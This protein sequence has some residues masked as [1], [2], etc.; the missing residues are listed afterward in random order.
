MK[1][2]KHISIKESADELTELYKESKDFLKP[3]IQLLMLLAQNPVTTKPKLARKLDV[4]YNSITKWLELYREGG[5][6]KLLEIKRG[7]YKSPDRRTLGFSPEIYAAI[8]KQHKTE[9]FQTYV[10]LHTWIKDKYFPSIK[11][12]TLIKYLNLH[13]GEELKIGRI[14]ELLI[15]ESITELEAL[16]VKCLPRIKP[17]VKMLITLKQNEQMS[18]A[19]LAKRLNVSYGSILK[20]TNIYRQGGIDEMLKYNLELVITPEVL[21]YIEKQ[22]Q[23]DKFNNFS[24]L[25][26]EVSKKYL[27][28]IKYYTLHRYI[29][30]HF[31][32]ELDAAKVLRMP[33]KE[34]IEQLEDLYQRSSASKKQRIKMLL[35][36][37]TMPGLTKIE[38]AKL[39]GV[40][41]GSIHRWYKLYK[42]GG[43]NRLME[44]RLRGRK[45]LELPSNIHNSIDRKLKSNPDMNLTELHTWVKTFHKSNLSYNKLYRYVRRHFIELP[46]VNF[47]TRLIEDRAF[48]RVA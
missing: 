31:A 9:P 48:N 11:Y 36:L 8:E 46:D 1:P 41:V 47:N 5:L 25:Y 7:K 17:R 32:S 13:F 19:E 26:K 10:E 2:I 37:K 44:I 12:S 6:E 39:S 28:G 23:Q 15:K 43:F 42:E 22:F 3:R 38:L 16:E 14:L 29:H 27:P 20:W 21:K 35:S 30:R 45:R 4:A 24:A 18:R 33:V 40:A 34:S